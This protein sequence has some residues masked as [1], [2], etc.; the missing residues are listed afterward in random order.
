MIEEIEWFREFIR[1]VYWPYGMMTRN[2]LNEVWV[3]RA[4]PS[5]HDDQ[6][7]SCTYSRID[8]SSEMTCFETLMEVSALIT[9]EAINHDDL[10]KSVSLLTYD[11]LILEFIKVI[12]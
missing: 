7:P 12:I 6:T 10:Q 3:P 4:W 9:V 1:N 8:D 2:L 5:T 11:R